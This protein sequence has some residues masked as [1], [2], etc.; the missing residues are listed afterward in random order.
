MLRVHD[1]SVLLCRP[2]TK[3]TRLAAQAAAQRMASEAQKQES[4]EV[5]VD[6]T[7]SD[8]ESMDAEE[9]SVPACKKGLS[10]TG[11]TPALT[12]YLTEP[13]GLITW[14]GF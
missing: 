7:S 4:V 8:S 1:I 14:S 6:L 3:S 2:A 5:F 12:A 10:L 11:Y 13:I 9:T